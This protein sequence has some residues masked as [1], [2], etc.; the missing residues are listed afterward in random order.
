MI[1]DGDN[2][3]KKILKEIQKSPSPLSTQ[4]LSLKLQKPWHSIQVRCLKL[5]IREKVTGFKVGRINLWQSN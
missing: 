3:Q 4:D 2:L 1:K 5:Q